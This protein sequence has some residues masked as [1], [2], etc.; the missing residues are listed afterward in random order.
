MHSQFGWHVI[1]LEESRSANAPEFEAVKDQVKQ[2]VQR[3]KLQ[4]YLDELRKNAKIEK[5]I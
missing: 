1:R 2:L 5:K 3:K 4:A